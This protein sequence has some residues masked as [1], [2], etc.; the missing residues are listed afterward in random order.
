MRRWLIWILQQEGS[1]GQ[2]ARGL[3]AGVFSGCFPLFGLQTIFGICIAK[4]IKG[5]LLLAASG[6]F[7]SN[8]FTYLPLYWFNY[9]VGS[10]LIGVHVRPDTT[11]EKVN[12]LQLISVGENVLLTLFIGSLVIGFISSIS[13]GLLSYFLLKRH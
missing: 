3:A 7:I 11:I 2:R 5:N 1:A 9:Q 10:R 4:I 8:P 6:T 13:L 12:L